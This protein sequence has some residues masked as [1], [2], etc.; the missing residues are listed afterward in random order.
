MLPKHLQSDGPRGARSDRAASGDTLGAGHFFDQRSSDLADRLLRPKIHTEPRTARGVKQSIDD[1]PF[2]ALEDS[3]RVGLGQRFPRCLLQTGQ[4][5]S[6]SLQL[7]IRE[8]VSK[9]QHAHPGLTA[10]GSRANAVN[11]S[12]V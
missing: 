8:P 11:Q 10:F 2:P 6:D 3:P 4:V 5:F 9:R 7:G 1:N 12:A